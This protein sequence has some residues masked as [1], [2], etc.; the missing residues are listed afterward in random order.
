MGTASKGIYHGYTFSG[1]LDDGNNTELMSN[2]NDNGGIG[3]SDYPF[4]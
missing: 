1:Y 4:E 2:Y 3:L